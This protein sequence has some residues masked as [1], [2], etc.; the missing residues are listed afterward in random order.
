MVFNIGD[1]V[2]PL[3]NS[4][5]KPHYETIIRGKGM[6][7]V[8][9]VGSTSMQIRWRSLEGKKTTHS[10]TIAHFE[11]YRKAKYIKDGVIVTELK[12]LTSEAQPDIDVSMYGVNSLLVGLELEANGIDGYSLAE[13]YNLKV[14]GRGW[15][16]E[17]VVK[18]FS[19]GGKVSYEHK[20][21]LYEKSPIVVDVYEDGSIEWELVTRPVYY[22]DLDRF[23]KPVHR[24]MLNQGAEFFSHGDGGLH[25]T[26][27]L[28]THKDLSNWNKLVVRNLIQLTRCFYWEICQEFP[29]DNGDL[30]RRTEYRSLNSRAGSR[31]AGYDGKYSAI[32]V[33]SDG[34]G[35]WGVEIRMPDGTCSWSKIKEQARFWMAMIRQSAVIS[36]QGFIELPQSTIDFQ[37]DKTRDYFEHNM[38]IVPAKERKRMKDLY[39][40]INPSLSLFKEQNEDK[41]TS[42]L[43]QEVLELHLKGRS[44]REITEKT[45]LK[46]RAINKILS[47]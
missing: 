23:V 31:T 16:M 3:P 5:G 4:D 46:Y 8:L 38:S 7:R 28:N 18:N 36:R 10:V 13:D 25:M 44:F 21:N 6:G 1:E 37:R 45:N 27:L 35:I 33:R 42:A 9:D 34:D 12:L 47:S 39:K 40:I 20:T 26:F 17:K 41:Y 29:G 15:K 2:I 14:N 30:T 32:N 43:R 24:K 22:R 19:D 11:L